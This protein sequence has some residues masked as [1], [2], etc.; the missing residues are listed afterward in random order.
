[1]DLLLTTLDILCLG[2]VLG[3]TVFF[4]FVQSPK[5]LQFM[6]REKFVT[7]QMKITS[8]FFTYIQ[9][10]LL[11]S[12]CI[13]YQHGGFHLMTAGCAVAGGM[14]NYLFIVPKVM[15]FIL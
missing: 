5:L 15:H 1:M 14:I 2:L 13:S 6:G 8:W 9:I 7:V 3:S 10:P 12:F 11:I 4:F